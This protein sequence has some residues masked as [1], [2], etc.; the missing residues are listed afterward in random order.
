M[1]NKEL[2]IYYLKELAYITFGG[3]PLEIICR[4]LND[5]S[6]EPKQGKINDDHAS[7][8]Y[9][10]TDDDGDAFTNF[11]LYYDEIEWDNEVADKR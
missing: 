1:F 8:K 2:I 10:I 5:T 4:F 3:L 6:E 11:D 9:T 7:A